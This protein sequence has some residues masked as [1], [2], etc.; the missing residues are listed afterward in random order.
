TGTYGQL[1]TSSPPES[2]VAWS[3]FITSQHSE[4]HGIYDFVHRD[5]KAMAP[6][7]STSRV[8]PPTT[9][10]TLGPWSLPVGGGKVELLRKGRPFWDYLDDEGIPATVL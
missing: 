10:L 8:T 5:P 9:V 6:Y 4:G 2:P 3:D 1:A 7:L